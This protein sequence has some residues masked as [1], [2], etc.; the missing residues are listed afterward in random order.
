VTPPV[1]IQPSPTG[2]SRRLGHDLSLHGLRRVSDSKEP[3]VGRRCR[4][5]SQVPPDCCRIHRATEP[6]QLQPKVWQSIERGKTSTGLPQRRSQRHPRTNREAPCKPGTSAP[7][8]AYRNRCPLHETPRGGPTGPASVAMNR[9]IAV[10]IE[11]AVEGP[12]EP[13][14]YVPLARSGLAETKDRFRAGSPSGTTE[15]VLHESVNEKRLVVLLAVLEVSI[16]SE[17]VW[18]ARL[19][20][21]LARV[22]L[23]HRVGVSNMATEHVHHSTRAADRRR[24]AERG[25]SGNRSRRL[26][27][28][29]LSSGLSERLA[30]ADELSG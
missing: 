8:W 28:F 14:R 3:C 15:H 27:G 30:R 6:G 2:G 19:A 11:T 25:P 4:N 5:G 16:A 13:A 24:S 1:S 29:P 20:T 26:V 10:P 18:R 21:C 23:F 9:P 7:W 17:L 22:R 12:A